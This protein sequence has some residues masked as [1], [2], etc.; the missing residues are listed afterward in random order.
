M[1]LYNF[2]GDNGNEWMEWDRDGWMEYAL[3]RLDRGE[4]TAAEANVL[5]VQIEGVRIVSGRIPKEVRAAL[6]EAVKSGELGHLK[7]EGLKPEAYFHKNA[8]A[9]A[10]EE[11][12]RIAIE[13]TESIKKSVVI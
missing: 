6:N 2:A 1:K 8:R 10:L 11:R 9:N 5:M 7:K 12:N 3:D 4:F 13:K